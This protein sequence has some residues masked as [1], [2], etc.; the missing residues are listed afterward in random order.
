[1]LSVLKIYLSEYIYILSGYLNIFCEYRYL[2]DAYKDEWI[3][4]GNRNGGICKIM[5][6]FIALWQRFIC[7]LHLIEPSTTHI[8]SNLS[9]IATRRSQ[10]RIGKLETENYLV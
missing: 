5:E 1:M 6:K 10:I 4:A 7:L 3:E 8:K 9:A 2:L